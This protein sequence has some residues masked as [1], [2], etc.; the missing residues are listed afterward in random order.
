VSSSLRVLELEITWEQSLKLFT[1]I[2]DSR[3]LYELS[4]H[5]PLSSTKGE[6]EGN[7]WKAPA[8]PQVQIFALEL[9][10]QVVDQQTLESI[11]FAE[12][13]HI[14]LKA[15]DNSLPHVRTLHLRP[16]IYT[17]DLV[18]IV[19]TMEALTSLSLYLTVRSNRTEKTVCPTLKILTTKDRDVR[20]YLSMPNITSII[21][22]HTLP[23]TPGDDEEANEP[24]DR[25]FASTLESISMRSE[26]GPV[27]LPNGGEFKQLR[28]LEWY[29]GRHGYRYQDGSFPSLTKIVFRY[30]FD[31]HAANAFC[32]S[33][34]RYPRLC[35]GLKAIRLPTYPEWDILLYMLLRRNVHYAQNSLSRITQIEI[36]GFPAP[37][38]LVPLKDLLL[39]RIPLEMPSPEELSFVGIE[40][41]YFDPMMYVD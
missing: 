39:G 36:L 30:A 3:Y 21:L 29:D 10:E 14:V 41:V 25:S 24:L 16:H 5:I 18:R 19:R 28:T 7:R 20:R 26:D 2:Q 34:L 23:H 35:P 31:P 12:A 15:L 22:T 9:T 37:C 33:L 6:S 1:I 38:I 32:E 40:D 4:L 8:L 17:N 27:I 11:D 13:A